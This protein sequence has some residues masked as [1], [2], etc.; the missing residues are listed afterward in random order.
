MA[1]S[2]AGSI[3]RPF[4][5]F[6]ASWKFLVNVRARR[7]T[8]RYTPASTGQ[9][10][11][12][13]DAL[14]FRDCTTTVGDRSLFRTQFHAALG[15]QESRNKTKAEIQ[16][17]AFERRERE[18]SQ[19]W[20]IQSFSRKVN[21]FLFFFLNLWNAMLT[22]RHHFFRLS[23]CQFAFTVYRQWWQRSSTWLNCARL[24][25]INSQTCRRRRDDHSRFS[26][27]LN[28]LGKF[29]HNIKFRGETCEPCTISRR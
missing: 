29:R 5:G 23:F 26:N 8:N 11:R 1:K 15:L 28:F 22:I 21:L 3:P 16:Q 7:L 25:Y 2:L 9:S 6:I 24:L 19:L 12:D 27:G 13:E 20:K 4:R 18:A 14:M 17:D 10:R